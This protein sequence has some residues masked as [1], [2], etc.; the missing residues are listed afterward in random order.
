M[1]DRVLVRFYAGDLIRKR[2]IVKPF[3]TLDVGT[4]LITS[5]P[6]KHAYGPA[7]NIEIVVR[8]FRIWV[9]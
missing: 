5:L 6:K 8:C 4:M 2:I 3:C 7:E 9:S 1:L